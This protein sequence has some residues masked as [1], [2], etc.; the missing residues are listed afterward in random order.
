MTSTSFTNSIHTSANAGSS[1]T[2][3]LAV[4]ATHTVGPTGNSIVVN[5]N[6]FPAGQTPSSPASNY[7][8]LN[9]S[10]SANGYNTPTALQ[11]Y[12]LTASNS[13]TMK[14]SNST[15]FTSTNER[16][17]VTVA[18]GQ[19]GTGAA[20]TN[21]SDYF[22]YDIYTGTPTINSSTVTLRTTQSA[23]VC[24]IYVVSGAANTIG[25]NAVTV[26]QNIGKYFYNSTQILT[27]TNVPSN[28]HEIGASGINRITSGKNATTL[29]N[30]VTFTNNSLTYPTTAISVVT[31]SITLTTSAYG[32]T[33]TTPVTLTS[34]PINM[35][36]DK[37]SY[38]LI[39]GNA[40]YPLT[41]S[42]Q[43]I[44]LN[45]SKYG[46]RISSAIA[47]GSAPFTYLPASLSTTAFSN[48]SSLT[49]NEDLL[50]YDGLY[51]TRGAD[52][53]ATGYIPYG[54]YVYTSAPNTVTSN[55]VDYS[56]ILAVGYRYA[57]FCF[58]VAAGSYDYIQFKV[59]NC[60]TVGSL[61]GD[62]SLPI[63]GSTRLYFY[64]KVEDAAA[65]TPVSG[66][67]S[68]TWL[69]ATSSENLIKVNTN[70]FYNNT[71][72]SARNSA[73]YVNPTYTIN[74]FCPSFTVLAQ[75]VNVYFR[76]CA[77]MNETFSFQSVSAQ[78]TTS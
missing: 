11:G 62:S 14:T 28:L 78:F 47:S 19:T 56:G 25:L 33:T 31:K 6:G 51:R 48:T 37:N 61:N 3:L 35:F 45:S 60:S 77:P 18:V 64:Y 70:N 27:Y 34:D 65:T 7:M 41:L 75:N 74:C 58:K 59:N 2:N 20:T 42:N 13:L 4:T 32:P 36:I 30:Q 50:I 9:T 54:S 55:T 72:L 53:T 76:I 38:D 22:Y 71:V 24:G 44:G 43:T 69:D 39:T 49:G 16:N 23:A 8:T 57:T 66:G 5:Y 17:N 29:D 1:L 52:A 15:T 10:A 21:Y 46:F 73:S 63:A 68:T 67:I 12:Y 26:V 40:L